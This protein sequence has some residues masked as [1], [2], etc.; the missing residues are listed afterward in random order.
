MD[1]NTILYV[2][3]F[4]V[5]ILSQVLVLNNINFLGFLNP[6]VYIVFILIAPMNID[7]SLFLILSFLLGLT[8]DM[9]GDSGGVHAAACL[10]TAF[11]R[12]VALRFVFGLSFEFQ[13]I[14]LSKVRFGE[15]F[16]YVTLMVFLH[17]LVLF[18]LEIFNLSHILIILKKTLFSSLFTIFITLMV[19]MLLR[20]NNS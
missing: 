9:F 17:H 3:R 5:L 6:Y 10:I 19:M 11:F 2:I 4:I 13:T 16:M 8:I 1:R 15:L 20:R 14:K 7:R 12:S 18:S